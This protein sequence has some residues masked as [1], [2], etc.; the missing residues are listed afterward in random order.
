[1]PFARFIEIAEAVRDQKKCPL[2]TQLTS[3]WLDANQPAKAPQP[4]YRW[5][6]DPLGRDH[7]DYCGGQINRGRGPS[8]SKSTRRSQP[9]CWYQM[10]AGDTTG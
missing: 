8:L 7:I 9:L 2:L 5:P 1:M 6:V 4:T 3:S 10:L